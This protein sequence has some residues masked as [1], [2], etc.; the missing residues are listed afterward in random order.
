MPPRRPG[1]SFSLAL[2][3]AQLRFHDSDPADT[4]YGINESSKWR[5]VGR[6]SVAKHWWIASGW[7]L[8]VA[9]EATL[10]RLAPEL[11]PGVGSYP[12]YT[13]RGVAALISASYD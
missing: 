6:A 1:V 8:G 4:F 5:L 3:V 2:L 12:S 9:G 11:R 7:Q 10:G 13:V